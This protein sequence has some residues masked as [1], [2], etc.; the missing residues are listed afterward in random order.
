MGA[1]RAR[2]IATDCR[3]EK[4]L[5]WARSYTLCSLSVMLSSVG[6]LF[7]ASMNGWFGEA[8]LPHA[9]EA[10]RQLRAVCDKMS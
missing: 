3:L 1:W 8:A 7:S 2:F 5:W 10:E 6:D 9:L 4:R